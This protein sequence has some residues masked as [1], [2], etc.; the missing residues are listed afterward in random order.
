MT[1]GGACP[2]DRPGR[3]LVA[4]PSSVSP[5]SGQDPR[6]RGLRL[7]RAR[8]VEHRLGRDVNPMIRTTAPAPIPFT[9]DEATEALGPPAN[10]I[11]AT[12]RLLTAQHLGVS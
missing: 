2:V 6:H 11:N 1:S 10:T 8:W 7:K 9:T 12:G 3:S 4:P 5:R